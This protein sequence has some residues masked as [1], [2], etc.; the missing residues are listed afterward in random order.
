MNPGLV[1]D[2][3]P[4]EQI[5]GTYRFALNVVQD[6]HEGAQ[7]ILSSEP[8]NDIVLSL[9]G[10]Y[11]GKIP[12]DASSAVIFA[13]GGYIYLFEK[14]TLTTLKHIPDLGFSRNHPVTGEFRIIRGCERVIYFCDGVNPDRYLNLDRLDQFTTSNDLRL[15]PLVSSPSIQTT[16]QT[17]GG[18]LEYGSYS[19]VIELLD[20]SLN[21]MYR[22]LTTPKVF[23]G[24][25]LNIETSTA[26]VGGKP[27]S[28]N[29][30]RLQ[31]SS[32]TEAATFVRVGVLKYTSSDGLTAT[33][34]Y[35]G[36]LFPQQ[37]G[38]DFVYTG[39]NASA[40]DILIDPSAI[41][42]AMV[43][44][45]S[46]KTMRQV[47]G[48]LLRMNL[49]QSAKD[50]S[51][52]Q[53]AASKIK[54]KYVIEEVEYNSSL[55]HITEQGDEVK[56]YGIVYVYNTGKV[57]DVFHI[58]G[59]ASIPTDLTSIT[60]D[61]LS[62]TVKQRWMLYNTAI[63]ESA[64]EGLPGYFAADTVYT[65]PANYCGTDY[66]GVDADG[67]TLLGK[68]VRYHRMPCR[69]L[70]PL[71]SGTKV[72]K[73]GVRF[74]EITFPHEDIVGYYIVSSTYE[75]GNR[76][77][78][79][80][81]YSIPFNYENDSLGSK[82]EGR[83]IHYL[84]NSYDNDRQT[85]TVLQNF[86]SLDYLSKGVL[87]SGAYMKTNGYL[88]TSYADNRPEFKNFFEDKVDLQLFGKH[89]TS[90]SFTAAEE[91][92][93][94]E[95]SLSLPYAS[96]TL[97]YP[98]RSMSSN[99]NIIELQSL[100]SVYNS[101]RSN[102]NYSYVKT[103]IRPFQ[104]VFGIRYRVASDFSTQSSITVM[105]GDVFI[106]RVDITNIS[107][108]FTNS[109]SSFGSTL[110]KFIGFGG[111]LLSSLLEQDQVNV[112]Y[113][114]I[115]GLY[116]ESGLNFNRRLQGL[117]CNTYYETSG[118]I[119]DF[120]ISRL[121]IFTEVNGERKWTVRDS[122]CLEWWG[123]NDDY[124][125][126]D[127]YVFYPLPITFNYCSSCPEKYPDRI[128]YS[129]PGSSEDT[130][131]AWKIFLPLNYV[132]I[133]ADRGEIIRADY[134]ENVLIVRTT[135]GA[136]ILQPS[137]QEIA[138]SGAT[139]YVGTGSFLSLPPIPLNSS[140]SGYG[141]QQS[142]LAS[143]VTPFGLVWVDQQHGKVLLF[144]GKVSEISRNGLF[145]FF[146]ENAS[147]VFKEQ[148]PDDY[149]EDRFGFVVGYDPK[150]ERVLVTKY[151]V[152]LTPS[153]AADYDSGKATYVDGYY[154]LAGSRLDYSNP[155]YFEQHSLA[156]SY[157]FRTNSW[158]SFHS[159]RPD[160]Y[161]SLGATMYSI[162]DKGIY[163]HHRKDKFAYFYGIEFPVTVGLVHFDPSTQIHQAVHY[164][165]VHQ[166]YDSK[167][168]TWVDDFTKTFTSAIAFT[169][170]QSSGD[171]ALILTSD[172]SQLIAWDTEIKTVVQVD[173]NY[174]IGGLRDIGSARPLWTKEW[175]NRKSYY[176][177][178]Q[179]YIDAVP[180]NVDYNKPQHE[181][182]YFRDKYLEVRLSF[183]SSAHRMLFHLAT[184][185]NLPSIR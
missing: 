141:G 48:K 120:I 121:A 57:T 125:L 4:Q 86:V 132:D 117:E 74:T 44:Y 106:S 69:T 17:S 168:R 185:R 26:D 12:L 85:N 160:D 30:I 38:V 22:S 143:Y 59:R 9:D 54:T 113:E 149:L 176:S 14:D 165:A 49:R 140:E 24:S 150:F 45:E 183:K 58:P 108:I 82:E 1:Q 78:S 18:R 87:A 93:G 142:V 145:Q 95:E 81:G 179:G 5:A 159:Y 139:I 114:Y 167:T 102:L 94:I 53:K 32:I 157:S 91:F 80:A 124:S 42:S 126:S 98:N 136:Y 181:Q 172:P 164:Y 163:K 161:L 61:L 116:F 72:R 3:Q 147:S 79:A 83:Y 20:A 155:V 127:N 21:V 109:E 137:P 162:L 39:F 29:S 90:T 148:Y 154:Y 37:G 129:N 128:I 27:L 71:I 171:V 184:M 122:M 144:D 51:T 101:N 166:K 11:A 173:K 68:P 73:I 31:V 177:L 103:G 99:F 66:W 75:L 156:A 170:T 25:A 23:V 46:S 8:G 110:L 56:A 182:L 40:G 107:D 123:Y 175:N 55:D 34:H 115:K 92:I 178:G 70:E 111:V 7:G 104:N 41:L 112:E 33:A 6:N 133:P 50:Y 169:Q 63:K 15:N 35:V 76:T 135:N 77:I 118:K 97:E 43:V 60:T 52:F 13:E 62:D 47:H 146:L 28:T 67:N 153:F 180:I 174:R 36:Q 2:V 10:N 65:N 138:A 131:D 158:T 105:S 84:P 152:K 130:E 100:P 96:L 16:L 89:H 119:D 151:D 88:S 64:T 19:F 134:V